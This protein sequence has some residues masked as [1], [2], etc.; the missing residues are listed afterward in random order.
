MFQRTMN[1]N[2][3]SAIFVK[4]Y[5]SLSFTVALNKINEAVGVIPLNMGTSRKG[6]MGK[7]YV[8]TTWIPTLLDRK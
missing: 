7:L 1:N 2:I 5:V 4:F 8:S 3:E 6:C